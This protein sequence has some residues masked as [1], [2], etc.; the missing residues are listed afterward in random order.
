M[1]HIFPKDITYTINIRYDSIHTHTHTHNIPVVYL[2]AAVTA[3]GAV[4]ADLQSKAAA[5]H[6]NAMVARTRWN[7]LA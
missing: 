7:E 3:S 5:R 6:N 1:T 2:R 4:T